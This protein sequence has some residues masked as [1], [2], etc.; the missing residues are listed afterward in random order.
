MPNYPKK[1]DIAREGASEREKAGKTLAVQLGR[2][3]QSAAGQVP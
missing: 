3:D 1:K 2:V